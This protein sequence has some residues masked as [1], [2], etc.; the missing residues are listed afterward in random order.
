M[1]R[2]YPLDCQGTM[3][4]DSQKKRESTVGAFSF[5]GCHA[6]SI[7]NAPPLGIGGAFLIGGALTIL[8]SHLCFGI[9]RRSQEILRILW[10][11]VAVAENLP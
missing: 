9:Q 5:L 7:Q 8:E 4:F 2:E 3:F 6:N 10:I 11:I 1:K